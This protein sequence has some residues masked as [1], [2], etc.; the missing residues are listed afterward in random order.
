[1][2][3]KR[4]V[5]LAILAGLAAFVIA[6]SSAAPAM[7]AGNG[8]EGNNPG[9]TSGANA[10]KPGKP[11][12]EIRIGTSLENSTLLGVVGETAVT[13]YL[14]DPLD[15][16]NCDWGNDPNWEVTSY[17]HYRFDN[18]WGPWIPEGSTP[19]KCGTDTSS[20]FKHIRSRH[21]WGSALGTAARIGDR[22]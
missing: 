20:G 15:T 17:W 7:A 4:R 21:Q 9:S 18:A 1:M 8:G 19:L 2:A 16:L 11:G 6:A 10:G 22:L 12:D 13:P 5:R 14:F 3:K